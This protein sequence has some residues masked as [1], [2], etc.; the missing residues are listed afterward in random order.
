MHIYEILKRPLT[1][2][3]TNRLKDEHRQYAFEVDLRAN[4]HE[5]KQAVE[6]A[7]PNIKVVHVN[8]MRMSRKRRHFGRRVIY[9]AVWKKAIVTIPA[10]QRIELFEGV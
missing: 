8:V 5:I 3:K 4:K 9:K 1:T 10:D 7:F 2:E 6:M